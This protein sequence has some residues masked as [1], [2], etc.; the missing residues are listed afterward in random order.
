MISLYENVGKDIIAAK[1]HISKGS[2]T[3][4]EIIFKSE[5]KLKEYATKG[6]EIFNRTYYGFIPT[7]NRRSFLPVKIRNVPLNDK[8][9][10]SEAIKDAF[11]GVGKIASIKPLLIEG[12]PYLTDQWIIIFDT[13]NDSDLE[14]RIPRF[15]ILQENK[16]TTEWKSAPKVCF[17]CDKEGHIKRECDQYKEALELRQQFKNFK[18]NKNLEEVSESNNEIQEEF[19]TRTREITPNPYLEENS[20]ET[21]NNSQEQIPVESEIEETTAADDK[22]NLNLQNSA[23]ENNNME[24]ST[25]NEEKDFVENIS[26]DII[27]TNS[28]TTPI[29]IIDNE[30]MILQESNQLED[31]LITAIKKKKKDKKTVVQKNEPIRVS[32]YKKNRKEEQNLQI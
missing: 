5:D 22:E 28:N 7:D 17:F 21:V 29:I 4:L 18:R 27:S 32:P 16:I 9:L 23:V 14:N 31:E 26:A 19:Q 1:P 20:R 12:T 2:R 3:H 30:K 10:I 25:P 6:V 24:I 8:N 11:D 13:T 15:Y